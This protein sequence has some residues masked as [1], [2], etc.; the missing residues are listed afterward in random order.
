MKNRGFLVMMM[1]LLM[2]ITPFTAE[3]YT[4]TMSPEM[5]QS[6]KQFIADNY[7]DDIT[8][9]ELTGDTPEEI[10]EH[11]DEHSQY[12]DPE[13]FGLF[14]ERLTGEYV[15]IGAYIDEVDGGFILDPMED[16]P[17]WRAGIKSGDEI[18]SID[19]ENVE[20]MDF[21]ELVGKIRGD[22]GTKITL[23]IK[24]D[25]HEGV[26]KITFE[27]D[28]ITYKV[29][30][31]EIIDDIGYLTILEFNQHTY[32]DTVKALKEF[33]KN[34]IDK[35]IIDLRNNPGGSLD[36]VVAIAR[37]LVKKGPILHV[38]QQ[39]TTVTYMSSLSKP[40][41]NNIVVLV[42]E[43]SASASEVLAAAIQD[44]KSGIIVG[45]NTYGKG[46]V[47]TIYY[48]PDGDGMKITEARY[49]SPNKRVIDGIGVKP[50]YKV[51]ERLQLDF[52]F[53]YLGKIDNNKEVK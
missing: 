52:A 3:A 18:I 16:S 49:L 1:V 28:Y 2:A 44:S 50:D 34:G 45:Q 13:T 32:D 38:N 19:G 6:L 5:M 46:S 26:M 21:E 31:S 4:S 17:S 41:F 22:V 35:I 23:G 25:G 12:F 27:R 53:A 11:L 30:F 39:D 24:R 37:L 33:Q 51:I 42:N 7:V 36:Q 43:Y 47:Q 48:L 9:E 40:F 10:F 8:V 14:M 29:V 15:G 20:G